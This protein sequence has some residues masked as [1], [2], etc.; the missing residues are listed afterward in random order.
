MAAD[1]DLE[2]RQCVLL[3]GRSVAGFPDDRIGPLLVLLTEAAGWEDPLTLASKWINEGELFWLDIEF[4]SPLPIGIYLNWPCEQH[5]SHAVSVLTP[6]SLFF[7]IACPSTTLLEPL[8]LTMGVI[9]LLPALQRI[10][11]AHP[12]LEELEVKTQHGGTRAEVRRLLCV[13]GRVG[14]EGVSAGSGGLRRA[15]SG[16]CAAQVVNVQTIL[17][18][19][20]IKGT[21]TSTSSPTASP[22]LL[23]SRSPA[24]PPPPSPPSP[25]AE[26]PHPRSP[27]MHERRKR[28]KLALPPLSRIIAIESPLP[29][30]ISE[31]GAKASKAS[32]SLTTAGYP[33]PSRGCRAARTAVQHLHPA[34]DVPHRLVLLPL[35]HRPWLPSMPSAGN[36]L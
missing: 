13:Y 27:L 15:R 22:R 11:S 3:C 34:T 23:P 7:R 12:N 31:A 4:F 10:I 14:F 21:R 35:P 32:P 1:L 30:A 29:P 26:D 2:S 25:L 6:S 17:A 28:I 24:S 8:V 9:S 5:L 18:L 36:R 33:T 16:D 20:I 19:D